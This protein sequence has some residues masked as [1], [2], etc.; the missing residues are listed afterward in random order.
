MRL[1]LARMLWNFDM[2]LQSSSLDWNDQ[3]VCWI[4]WPQA[5]SDFAG[6]ALVGESPPLREAHPTQDMIEES[7]RISPEITLDPESKQISKNISH[8]I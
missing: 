2:E 6:L 3:K 4:F 5:C 1:I 7:T 8:G